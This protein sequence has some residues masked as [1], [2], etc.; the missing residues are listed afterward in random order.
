M[1]TRIER[2]SSYLKEQTDAILQDGLNN[3]PGIDALLCALDLHLDRANVSKD[4]NRLWK[5][6]RAVKV[7]GKPV[8]YLDYT[9]LSRHF[10]NQYIPSIISKNENLT[11]F[12]SMQPYKKVHT[13]NNYFNNTLDDM[14]GAKGSLSEVIINAKSA[15]SYPPY[16]IHCLILGNAGVGKT[17]LTQRMYNFACQVRKADSIPFM[18]L[19][20]QN[21]QENPQLFSE[22]LFGSKTKNN[23]R[24]SPSIFE[25]CKNGIIVLEQIDR[26][27]FSCQTQLASILSRKRY[28]TIYQQDEQQLQSMIIATTSKNNDDCK[29]E[30]IAKFMPIQ[31]KMEDIDKR[32]IYEKIEL[33]MDLFSEE[34]IHT[35]TTIRV[36]KDIIAWL[37]SKKFPNNIIQMR[38]EIQISCSKAYMEINDPKKQIVYVSFQS[39]SLELLSQ[40][41]NTQNLNS[42][43]FSLLS[44]IPSDYLQFNQDGTSNAATIFK[45][46]PNMFKEHRMRQF[47]DEFNVNVEE[48]KDINHY[49]KENINVLKDCPSPQLEGLHKNINPYVYQVTMQKINERQLLKKLSEHPQLLYGIL[50]HITNYISRIEHGQT[51]ID[52][53]KSMTKY[54]Y[55]NEY[56]C[57]KD[58]YQE[59]SSLYSFTPSEREIDFLASYL[60]IAN[61]W[62]NHIN[63]AILVI[64][65][66]KHIA[67]EMV[68]YVKKSVQG[69]F[70]ID[71]IDFNE[72]MQLNDLLELAC[73]KAND[74][75][76]GAGVLIT[77]DME[78]L[79]SVSEYIHKQTNIPTKSVNNINLMDLLNLT[80][81]T[82]SPL[83]D[84][85]Q[86]RIKPDHEQKKIRKETQ[87][88]FIEQI[89]ERVISKTVSFI[90]V[91]KSTSILETCLK[92]TLK[93]LHMEYT[94]VLAI[95]YLCHCTNMLE[96]IIRNETWD[97]QKSHLFMKENSYMIHV[98]EHGLEFAAN[99][100]SIK[101]PLSE[102][103]YVTQIFLPEEQY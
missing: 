7:Q 69:T 91:N 44:C 2:I 41:E 12:L 98:I 48:L 94:D 47:I 45:N 34:A 83:N 4:L 18:T 84:L 76:Q 13:E 51:G 92:N 85:D 65:H 58:I 1:T 54:V 43:I 90:D 62:I 20:C 23:S 31:L 75:N 28:H 102:L 5:E 93:E 37:A 32:G 50:L 60:A 6:G 33:I 16:G 57:A 88:E 70:F 11:D 64:C 79:T 101:I 35:H 71:S 100:F 8:Y 56:L 26:L 53:S 10:P 40:T 24:Y 30:T 39:L 97:Y 72:D 61:Q 42:N 49:V 68:D 67:S 15:I 22:A 82:T 86:I 59:F 27:P 46:A 14:I 52:T 36:H 21:Y 19:S 38:N 63:V 74:L 103:I 78:P 17:L 95:K 81:Q 80:N 87:S 99:S 3:E 96:R 89:K 55:H 73:I 9:V 25:T 66:G 29:I 77:C